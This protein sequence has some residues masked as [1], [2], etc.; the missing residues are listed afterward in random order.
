M[1]NKFFQLALMAIIVA[2]AISLSCAD[3]NQLVSSSPDETVPDLAAR[4]ASLTLDDVFGDHNPRMIGG[5]GGEK[6]HQDWFLRCV[7]S[8]DRL[9]LL[10]IGLK[11]YY[12]LN[13]RYPENLAE[14]NSA[15]FVHFA[16]LDPISQ[17]VIKYDTPPTND[18]DFIN[19]VLDTSSE[20]WHL[21]GQIPIFPEGTWQ[22]YTWDIAGIDES[23]RNVINSLGE[24]YS[25][26]V[27]MKGAYMAW[28]FEHMLWDY[29]HRRATMPNTGEELLDGLWE[30]YNSSI[31][32]DPAV[33]IS[34]PGAFIFGID[35]QEQLS[36]AIWNDLEGNSYILS[37]T[38]D[39]WPHGW[40]H[41]PTAGENIG[42]HGIPWEPPSDDFVPGSILWSCYL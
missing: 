25:N 30:V 5:W 32:D 33:D 26:P 19:M 34:N 39:P 11:Y 12:A 3:S 21:T 4:S 37:W 8:G 38:W 27:A 14:L 31:T 35:T 24:N 29:E 20:P 1:I 7:R 23:T 36:V 18:T 41:V 2:S 42:H 22:S 10:S 40:D 15:G 6:T 9:E 13:D 28:A 17:A 16:A